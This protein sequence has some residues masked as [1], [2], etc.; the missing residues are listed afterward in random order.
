MAST[1]HPA[2]VPTQNPP[3]QAQSGIGSTITLWAANWMVAVAT[4]VALFPSGQETLT[5]GNSWRAHDD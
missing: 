2:S 5:L 3:P 4:E 1:P